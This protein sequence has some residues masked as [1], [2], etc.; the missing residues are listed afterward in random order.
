MKTK[1][2]WL[3]L[4][5]VAALASIH[6]VSSAATICMPNQ[7]CTGTGVKPTAG[8][9]LVGNSSSTY[10]PAYLTASGNITIATSSGGILI[11]WVNGNNF[12]T[13]NSLSATSP[14]TYNSTT[15]QF[16]F[17]N[18]GYIT[19]STGLTAA[20]FASPNVS[21]WTNDSSYATTGAVLLKVNN[22]S[23]LVS[24][25]SAR[26]NLGLGT[27]ATQD[28][29]YF[30]QAA[31]N[32]S[33]LNSSTAARS[34][35]GLGTAA[36]RATGDFLASTT[37]Y[38]ATNTGN[39]AGTWQGVNSSTFYLATNPSGYIAT[40]TNLTTANFAT[41]SISQWNNNAGFITSTLK[42]TYFLIESPGATEDDAFFISNSTATISKIYA[43]HKT[44]SDTATFNLGF[45]TSRATATSSVDKAFTSYQ[46]FTATTTPTCYAVTTSTACP[47]QINGSST[48]PAGGVMRLFT[49]A[50]SSTQMLI[51][52]YYRD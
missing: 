47:N 31:N 44:N 34:N 50:A 2:I 4:L 40:S 3:V 16:G 39:W 10:T 52:V 12:I 49:S 51:N 23:E 42:Q 45:G 30:L 33:D 9:V 37:V 6:F 18:P 20:N 15:G 14:L 35:L 27:A 41:T 32:L 22:L 48:I 38:V 17:V 1:T 5:G 36:T 25:S 46:T 24:T 13:L 26:T 21:Q 11:G 8:K 7:G 28:A 43:V 19:T 29:T